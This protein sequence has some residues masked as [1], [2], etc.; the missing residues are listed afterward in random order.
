MLEPLTQFICDTCVQVIETPN[1]LWFEWLSHYDNTEN[2]RIC[3]YFRIC[4][5]TN[6]YQVHSR[7]RSCSDL[8]LR[9]V[10]GNFAPVH[11]AYSLDIGP[12]HDRDY[13][14]PHLT[15]LRE[16][17]EI[18]RRLTLP[19]YEET[20]QYWGQAMKDCYFADANEIYIYL[21]NNLRRMIEHYDN[22]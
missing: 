8:P 1:D 19:Y 6:E 14:G 9:D 10:A 12:Y 21:P 5:H 18:M 3:Q 17:T 16:F 11:M 13:G 15:D 20:R 4:H 7:D 22:Q 2:R